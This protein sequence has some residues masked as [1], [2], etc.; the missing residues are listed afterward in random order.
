MAK[1]GYAVVTG[2]AVA[3]SAATAKSVLG[4][5]AP[6][7][8]GIDLKK[9][10]VAF[11]GVTATN[12]PVLVE[13]CAATFATNSP[14]T[15]STSVTPVQVYG[16]AVTVGATAARTWTTE[17]TVLTVIGEFLLS[18]AGGVVFYDFPLGD[19]PDS[20]VSEGFV[21]RCNAPAVVNVRAS[22][23]FERC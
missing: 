2:G 15:N 13:L 22:L 8:N 21:I 9:F 19:T 12:V 3:L 10:R 16:R 17:P 23:E 1:A 20:A 11:D 5:K 14:G 18:P 4:V 6:S 7:G